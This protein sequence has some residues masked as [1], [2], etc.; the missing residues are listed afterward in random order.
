MKDEEERPGGSPVAK[1]KK[2][3]QDTEE[4]LPAA[5]GAVHAAIWLLGLALLFWMDWIW[6]G[7]LVLVAISILAQAGMQR[8]VARQL[9]KG[10]SSQPAP[11]GLGNTPAT[12]GDLPA[13]QPEL[14]TQRA[15][16]LPAVCPQCGAPLGVQAVRWSGPESGNCPYCNALLRPAP[17]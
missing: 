17:R 2:Q 13:G 3:K 10:Q 15:S 11:S 12:Q 8:Y 7:I 5:W 9:P 1:D 16:W 6:P 14:E 4:K